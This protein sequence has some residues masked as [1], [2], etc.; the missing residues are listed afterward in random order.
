MSG[1]VYD[2]ATVER[3]LAA[4]ETNGVPAHVADSLRL[5][6]LH[7]YAPGSFTCA[8][9]ENDL[10]NAVCRM[11]ADLTAAHLVAIVKTLYNDFPSAAWGSAEKRTAWTAHGGA[12]G[13]GQ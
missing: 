13:A 11:G 2:P 7:G 6:A 1:T 10:L 5:Y 3:D 12:S 9:I 8:C 4:M